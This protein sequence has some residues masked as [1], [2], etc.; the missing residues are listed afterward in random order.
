VIDPIA[1]I[2]E[3]LAELRKQREDGIAQVNAVSGAIQL[4][5]Q[6][7]AE[8]APTSPADPPADFPDRANGAGC[9]A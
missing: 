4:A 7:L 8:L 1:R 6:L 2:T 9:D 5:E 3:R